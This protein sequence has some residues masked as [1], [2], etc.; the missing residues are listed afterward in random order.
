M[1]HNQPAGLCNFTEVFNHDKC[2][3]WVPLDCANSHADAVKK[4]TDADS[5]MH[6]Q[7]SAHDS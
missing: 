3:L 7:A 1:Q 4:A 5:S 6:M 2:H